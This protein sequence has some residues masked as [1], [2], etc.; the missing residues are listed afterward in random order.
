MRRRGRELLRE[1]E[2]ADRLAPGL[3]FPVPVF[4]GVRAQCRTGERFSRFDQFG[5]EE[6]DR[7]AAP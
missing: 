5:D 1:I 3:E 4:D 2:K 7:A 6:L